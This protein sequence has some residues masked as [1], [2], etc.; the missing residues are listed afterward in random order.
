[1][2]DE[3]SEYL[4]KLSKS[5]ALSSFIMVT[6][7]MDHSLHPGPEKSES[8]LQLSG[9]YFSLGSRVMELYPKVVDILLGNHAQFTMLFGQLL[10]VVMKSL[11]NVFPSLSSGLLSTPKRRE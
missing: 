9:L 10:K 8:P 6:R 11:T 3:F 5:S 1:M 2:M 7:N 4:T